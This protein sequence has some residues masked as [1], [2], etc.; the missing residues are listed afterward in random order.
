M[1]KN[2]IKYSDTDDK[3]D[4]VDEKKFND[5]FERYKH[6]VQKYKNID[7]TNKLNKLNELNKKDN[8]TKIYDLSILEIFVNIKDTWFEILDDIL[9]TKITLKIFTK[10][11]RLFYIGITIFIIACALYL[12]NALTCNTDNINTHMKS[13]NMNITKVYHLNRKIKLN[14]GSIHNFSQQRR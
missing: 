2:N 11:N 8:Y 14:P 13:P 12:Y 1:N 5:D 7:D 9:S 6:F 10:E 4:K 3:D